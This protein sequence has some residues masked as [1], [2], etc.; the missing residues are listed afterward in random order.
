[1]SYEVHP[2][3]AFHPLMLGVL[4]DCVLAP[5]RSFWYLMMGG[6]GISSY[7]LQAHGIPGI[8]TPDDY[9]PEN[10]QPQ[11]RLNAL[12]PVVAMIYALMYHGVP[13]VSL[14]DDNWETG[15]LAEALTEGYDFLV[16]EA[17]DVLDFGPGSFRPQLRL[18]TSPHTADPPAEIVGTW[19]VNE[20][21]LVR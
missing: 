7:V 10:Y 3:V 12:T 9:F 15:A 18:N 2:A 16:T 19:K 5:P 4:A 11:I 20:V 21:F 1:V 6:E 8:T 13:G 17:G 14:G